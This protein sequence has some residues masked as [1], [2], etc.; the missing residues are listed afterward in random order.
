[1]G[2]RRGA[3][4]FG[5]EI[6][7]AAALVLG[8]PT[9]VV[10]GLGTIGL[11]LI[12]WAVVDS[13]RERRRERPRG[14]PNRPEAT[15]VLNRAW[16]QFQAAERPEGSHLMELNALVY[17]TNLSTSQP[18][19]FLKARLEDDEGEGVVHSHAPLLAAGVATDFE[20]TGVILPGATEEIE[21]KFWHRLG[22]GDES[23][24]IGPFDFSSRIVLLDQY[25]REHFT[26]RIG[27]GG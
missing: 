16:H 10:V 8:L 17:V 6:L 11:A 24:T 19:R 4:G 1:M 22:R 5:F 13:W 7:L 21:C 20:R 23:V 12:V 25:K 15:F 18:L 3:A 9:P 27:W 14:E 26:D 2:V